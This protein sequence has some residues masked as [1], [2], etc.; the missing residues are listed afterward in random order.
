MFEEVIV[1]KAQA[2]KG[3][4]G[5]EVWINPNV[6]GSRGDVKFKVCAECPF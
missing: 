1:C 3:Q 5:C 6:V 4:Y 2:A